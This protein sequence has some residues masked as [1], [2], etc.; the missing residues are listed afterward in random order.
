M[1]TMLEY[2]LLAQAEESEDVWEPDPR[3]LRG[4]LPRTKV[5]ERRIKWRVMIAS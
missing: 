2:L 1:K 3:A 4:R 5:M